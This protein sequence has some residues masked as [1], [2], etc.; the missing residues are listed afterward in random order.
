MRSL[1]LASLTSLGLLLAALACDSA[2]N[3]GTPVNSAGTSAGAGAPSGS[4]GSPASAAGTATASAGSGNSPAGSTSSGGETSAGAGALGASGASAGGA[5]SAAGASGSAGGQ[6]VVNLPPLV[7]SAPGAYWKTDGALTE[8][9]ATVTVTVNDT[10][11]LQ[12]WDGFGGAF[13]E[14]GWSFLSTTELQQQALKLLFSASEGA[15]FAWGRVPIGASDYAVSRYTLDDTGTD[16]TPNSAESNRPAADLELK[17]FSLAR[18]NMRLIPY[19]KAAQAVKGDLHFWASPW[20]PPVWMKT[21]YKKNSGADSSQ[22]AKMPSYFDGGNAKNDD[23]L[24]SAYANYFTKFVQGYQALGINI[25]VVSPQ[26]E[27]GYDQN[28]PSCLWD[29]A[30]YTKF[31]GKFLGPAMKTLNVALMLGTLSNAN[32]DFDVAAAA[33][34]DSTAKSYLT[35]IGSQ[36]NTLDAAKLSALN[37][38]LPVW[39]TEHK[40]GNYPFCKK[41][42]DCAAEMGI[43]TSA[44]APNDQAYGV[45]SWG[46][47]KNAITTIKVTAYNAWNMVLDKNGLGID[48]TREWKQD[49]LLVVDGGKLTPTPAYYVF[50]HLSQYVVPGAKVVGTTGGDAL[51]FKNPDG[52][53]V[54]VMFNS[55]AANPNYVVAIGGKKFQ[56]AMPGNGWATVKY[57]P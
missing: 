7:T 28:Y 45:E 26:N 47:I 30:T 37:A 11:L 33:L 15:N 49:A 31:I 27:P 5:L 18:D 24:L 6:A 20:T 25:E 17:S 51:A 42:G 13:N 19:I 38:N 29:G 57:K 14:L 8:S 53:L 9:T 2:N 54:A 34:A 39:A 3:S 43:Y 21:G 40:C 16:V 4:A 32:T 36:W 46:Y 52:S 48:T 10:T 1:E 55:G 23:Q 22:S 35:V 44:Q 56:F 12:K 41:Q 50:R